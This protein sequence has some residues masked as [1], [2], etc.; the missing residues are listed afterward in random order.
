MNDKI[1]KCHDDGT[2]YLEMDSEN[3]EKRLFHPSG[4]LM[5][6]SPI[7]DGREIGP[8]TMYAEDG[9]VSSR[10]FVVD[11]FLTGRFVNYLPDGQVLG[12]GYYIRHKKVSRAKYLRELPNHPEWPAADLFYE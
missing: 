3:G 7:V 1:R 5:A 11:G 8:I 4:K 2:V 9:T 12:E 10:G 6:V